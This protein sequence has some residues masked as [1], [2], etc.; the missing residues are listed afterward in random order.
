MKKVVVMYSP[1]RSARY[2][3]GYRIFPWPPETKTPWVYHTSSVYFEYPNAF[4]E[5]FDANS[6]IDDDEIGKPPPNSQPYR[7]LSVSPVV[8]QQIYLPPGSTSW[9]H[10][11]AISILTRGKQA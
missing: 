4:D 10:C 7:N 5:D 2:Y 9:C 8:L 11:L 3:G 6:E 1:K